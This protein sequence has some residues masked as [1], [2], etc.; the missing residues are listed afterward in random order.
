[1]EHMPDVLTERPTIEDII[2]AN[3]EG[4]KKNAVLSDQ[5]RFFNP[6][7]ICRYYAHSVIFNPAFY[8][9]AHSESY[10]G[11]RIYLCGCF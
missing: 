11:Y 7:E 1:M 2:L 10:G 6:Q 5:K 4:R 8:A 9:L 3:V